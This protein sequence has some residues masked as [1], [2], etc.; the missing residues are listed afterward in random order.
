MEG[1]EGRDEGRA[2]TYRLR[3]VLSLASWKPGRKEKEG[4]QVRTPWNVTKGEAPSS[5]PLATP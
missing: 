4:R 1:E 5:K 2:L 3:R